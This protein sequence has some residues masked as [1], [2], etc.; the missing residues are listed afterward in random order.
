MIKLKTI[1]DHS[2]LLLTD[3]LDK[4]GLLCEQSTKLV[5]LFQGGK[6]IFKS[7]QEIIDFFGEDIFSNLISRK[8]KHDAKY[9]VNGY[10]AETEELHQP[11]GEFELPVYTKTPES[12]VYYAAGYYCINFPKGWLTAY[13]PKLNTL[14][15]YGY[16]GPH[17]TDS[18][19][20][21]MYKKLRL[22]G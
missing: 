13:C 21:L 2:W 11:D 3:S 4:V 7:R 9:Y 12:K 10:P 17:K 19:N 18:D 16:N 15:K 6:T 14:T 8:H 22:N 1:T 20:K 5:L